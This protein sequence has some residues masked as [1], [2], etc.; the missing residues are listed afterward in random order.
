MSTWR[1]WQKMRGIKGLHPNYSMQLTLLANPDFQNG[2]PHREFYVW[3][4]HGIRN[5]GQFLNAETH[6]IYTLSELSLRYPDISFLF[7][8]Y[9]QMQSYISKLLPS[10]SWAEWNPALQKAFR[11]TPSLRGHTSHYYKFIH[12]A[13]YY[14]TSQIAISKWAMDDP[15]LGS[16]CSRHSKKGLGT[17]RLAVTWKWPYKFITDLTLPH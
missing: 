5:V 16:P 1:A 6:K 14:S 8:P 4:R 17:F 11:H 2:S 13:L 12:T 7:F 15:D 3:H 9:L 10:F